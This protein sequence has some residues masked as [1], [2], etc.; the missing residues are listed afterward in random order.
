M[1]FAHLIFIVASFLHL[2]IGYFLYKQFKQNNVT[3]FAAAKSFFYAPII[4][5]TSLTIISIVYLIF[6]FYINS[7]SSAAMSFGLIPFFML[8]FMS[9]PLFVIGILIDL[10][11]KYRK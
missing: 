11:L 3:K 6:Y 2:F 4:T 1:E 8:I 7:D 10:Y 5:S 9:L